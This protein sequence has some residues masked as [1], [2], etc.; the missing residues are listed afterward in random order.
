MYVYRRPFYELYQVIAPPARLIV[1]SKFSLVYDPTDETFLTETITF[2]LSKELNELPVITEI[3]ANDFTTEFSDN[4]TISEVF[5]LSYSLVV[6]DPTL[7]TTEDMTVNFSKELSENT[8][9][10]E[11]LENLAEKLLSEN[12]ALT[13]AYDNS[14]SLQISEITTLYDEWFFRKRKVKNITTYA[15]KPGTL[16]WAEFDANLNDLNSV[17]VERALNTSANTTS[18]TPS[19]SV[20]EYELTALGNA[21]TIN[22]PTGTPEDGQTLLF[23]IKSNGARQTINWHGIY[24]GIGVTLPSVTNEVVLYVGFIYNASDSKLDCISSN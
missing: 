24:R 18:L 14:F 19:Y 16:T 15:G 11:T 20:S 1:Y 22:A 2:D 10:T 8:V 7:N 9:L 4:N 5:E 17:K 21:L 12:I 23:K 6:N 3:I 13:E